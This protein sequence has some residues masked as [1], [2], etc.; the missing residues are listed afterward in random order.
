M[1]QNDRVP[2][3]HQHSLAK[4]LFRTSSYDESYHYYHTLY[5]ICCY[6]ST[7]TL[8]QLKPITILYSSTSAIHFFALAPGRYCTVERYYYSILYYIYYSNSHTY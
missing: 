5:S 1:V 4:L 6:S 3:L 2:V 8:F 7:N